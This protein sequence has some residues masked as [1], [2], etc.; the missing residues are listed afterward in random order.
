MI[1]P[2]TSWARLWSR[3]GPSA[4][5]YSWRVPDVHSTSILLYSLKRVLKAKP[6]TIFL[7]GLSLQHSGW[8]LVLDAFAWDLK[9]ALRQRPFCLSILGC[10]C[11]GTLWE[12]EVS[13]Q[14]PP[15]PSFLGDNN[16]IGGRCSLTWFL[17]PWCADTG[18]FSPVFGILQQWWQFGMR[19]S[20]RGSPENVVSLWVWQEQPRFNL[21]VLYL[22]SRAH[23]QWESPQDAMRNVQKMAQMPVS[24]H[25]MN[26]G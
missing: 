12:Q 3:K 15:T 10:V 11:A 25:K 23:L 2:S 18:L 8:K 17:I 1:P 22:H 21:S 6:Q 7:R 9:A 16:S 14:Q 4:Y 24:S 20:S 5:S 13:H 26:L 19:G